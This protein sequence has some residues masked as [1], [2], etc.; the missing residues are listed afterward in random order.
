MDM[1]L[2]LNRQAGPRFDHEAPPE[3]LFTVSELIEQL[4]GFIRRHFPIFIFISSCC[5]ALSLVY[6]LTTPPSFTSHAM[7]LINS[8]KVRILQQDSPLN[9]LPID[10][11]Q[12]ETQV[13][14][15]KSESIGLSV[16][17][18][19]KLTKDPEF[20]GQE[21]GLLEGYGGFFDPP[22]C[23]RMTR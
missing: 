4:S 2:N 16:I 12:V 11:A 6:L 14:I 13:E 21:A 15:L 19:L 5:V 20:I 22:A 7:L 18:D 3:D 10:T 23:N 17:K 8:S 9:D 1:P